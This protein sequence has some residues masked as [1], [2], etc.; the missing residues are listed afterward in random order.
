MSGRDYAEPVAARR[1]LIILLVV[2][3]VSILAAALIPVPPPTE[4]TTS[5]ATR[6]ETRASSRILERTLGTEAPRPSV[7]R[8]A[9]GDFLELTIRSRRVRQVEIPRLG[10]L[11][12]LGP[13]DPAT[14]ELAPPQAGRYAIRLA[15]SGRVIA[16]LEVG[17]G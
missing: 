9:A 13:Y 3:G 7:I 16:R 5:S 11:E 17:P 10:V 4:R 15:G 1:L 12:D 14:L 2:F 6:T 8:L